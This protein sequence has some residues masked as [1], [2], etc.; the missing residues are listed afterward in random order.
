[1]PSGVSHGSALPD[2]AAVAARSKA[3][4]AKFGM[5]LMAS[6]ISWCGALCASIMVRMLMADDRRHLLR[7]VILL[8]GLALQVGDSHHP[9]EARF[10]SV[11]SGRH[12]PG[13]AVKGAG[14]D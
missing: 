6:S 2:G 3:T 4:F 14:H 10:S 13:G 1:M 7:P 8:R 5:R 12:Q 9:A 11:L